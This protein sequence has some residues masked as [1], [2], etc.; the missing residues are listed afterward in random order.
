M[1]IQIVIK[2]NCAHVPLL[3]LLTGDYYI[4]NII[5]ISCI[6]AETTFQQVKFCIRADNIV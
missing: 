3:T 1:Y 2:I 5:Y 4:L 6:F